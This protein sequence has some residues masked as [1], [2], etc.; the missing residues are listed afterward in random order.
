MFKQ[1]ITQVLKEQDCLRSKAC[2]ERDLVSTYYTTSIFNQSGQQPLL[3]VFNDQ[4]TTPIVDKLEDYTIT[5]DRFQIP[6]E[7]IPIMEFIPGSYWVGLRDTLSGLSTIEEVVYV[8]NGDFNV[9]NRR[10]V[11]FF[12]HMIRMINTAYE[13]AFAALLLIAPLIPVSE[14][15]KM[16]YD[17]ESGLF[18]FIV[19]N[20]YDS[21]L[22]PHVE[23]YMNAE[24]HSLF[25]SLDNY[26]YGYNLPSKLDTRI[27][28]ERNMT[29]GWIGDPTNYIQIFQE[30]S[31]VNIWYT[32]S[33]I[34]ITSLSVPTQ[35]E[36]ISVN[37]NGQVST[38]GS[39]LN[40]MASFVPVINLPQDSRG[41]LIFSAENYRYINLN[42]T[43][44]LTSFSYQIYYT[45][46]YN[47]A[48]PL[49]I[50]PARDL[51]IRFVFRNKMYLT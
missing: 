12:N 33:N 38:S 40:V 43:G 50:E 7:A 17:S 35:G 48:Y 51:S 32:L 15:P 8:P 36:G 6:T 13:D 45:D 24:L 10:P 1:D 47:N 3:A 21:S 44:V 4:R 2:I 23:I 29:N 49:Y 25:S 19:Q 20:G 14:S 46:R 41:K 27:I 39:S 16:F 26:F 9:F 37:L 30:Y 31:T 18:S 11:Y 28:L 22:V 42:K 5:V 34:I